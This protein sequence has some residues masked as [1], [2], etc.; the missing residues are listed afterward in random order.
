MESGY[1]PIPRAFAEQVVS[2]IELL[3]LCFNDK[4]FLL[5]G[6]ENLKWTILILSYNS[7]LARYPTTKAKI[8]NSYIRE[9]T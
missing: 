4:V 2:R 6:Q 1:S 5:F 7:F 8:W 9:N 3:L